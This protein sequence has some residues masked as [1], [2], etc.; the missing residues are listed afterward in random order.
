MQVPI[1]YNILGG[2]TYYKNIKKKYLKKC[3][4]A[5]GEFKINMIR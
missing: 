4:N 5:I 2:W 1:C 3:M